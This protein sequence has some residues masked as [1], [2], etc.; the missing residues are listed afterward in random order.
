M[1]KFL[2]HIYCV[3]PTGAKFVLE[4]AS[5]YNNY[6]DNLDRSYLAHADSMGDN[7]ITFIQL[8]V[9]RNAPSAEQVAGVRNGYVALPYELNVALWENTLARITPEVLAARRE[10]KNPSWPAIIPLEGY[11]ELAVLSEAQK[12]RPLAAE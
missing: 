9:W 6:Q 4:H 12:T 8:H 5:N 10:V 1:A 2:A 3:T 7:A 11:E